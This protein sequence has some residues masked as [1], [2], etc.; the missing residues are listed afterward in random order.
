MKKLTQNQLDVLVVLDELDGWGSHGHV[1]KYGLWSASVAALVTEGVIEAREQEDHRGFT[2][3]EVR[4]KR[5]R[6]AP[7]APVQH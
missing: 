1:Q 2:F 5:L 4:T 3:Q 7:D 6:S